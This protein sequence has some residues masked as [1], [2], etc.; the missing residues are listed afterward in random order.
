MQSSTTLLPQLVEKKAY[1]IIVA[2][3]VLLAIILLSG[4]GCDGPI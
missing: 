2:T 4:Y 1:E 3:A